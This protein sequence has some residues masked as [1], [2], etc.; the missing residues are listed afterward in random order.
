MSDTRPRRPGVVIALV[1]VLTALLAG[2]AGGA[3]TV[4][5]AP[6]APTSTAALTR[7][8]LDAWLD[9][10]VPAGLDR[11]GIAGAAVTVVRDG[12]VLTSRGYGL[13]DT[14]TG[15]PV[16]PER[17]LFR[18]GS[19]A[20]VFTATAVLQLVEQ[21]RIDLDADVRRHLDFPLPLRFE[22]PVTMRHLL[23]HSAGFEERIR[24]LI[25][26]GEGTED[27]RDH[28]A[29]DPPAQVFAP[30]TTP[31]YSNYGYGLAGYVV[32][33]VSGMP[34]ADYVQRFVLDPAGMSSSTFAQPLP[35]PLRA[36]LS[37]AFPTV[38][39]P[40]A[41]FETVRPSPAG[42]LTASAADMAR[43]MIAELGPPTLLAPATR[44]LMRSPALGAD[45]L[46]ALAE[47]PRTGLGLFDESRNGRRILGHGGD[48]Q[49]FHSHL[50][51]HPAE[52]TGI[53]VT[54][55][56]AG[57]GATDSLE[58][59]ETVL[60]GF[61]DRY[62]P[63]APAVGG[64]PGSAERAAQAQGTYESARAPFTT[65]LS[66]MNLGG[67]VT[68]TPRPDGTLL[69]APG[70]LSAHPAVYREVRPWVWQEAGGQRIV[71]MRL[72]QGRVA[73]LGVEGAF[74]LLPAPPER[75]AAIVLP[76]L[77]GAVTVLLGALVAWPVGAWLRRRY[78]R[79]VAVP[80][81]ERLALLATWLGAVAAVVA[82][83]GW[84]GAVLAISGLVDVPTPVLAGLVG[85]QVLG[86]WRCC[87]PRWRWSSACAAGSAPSAWP[88]GCWS[89]WRSWRSRASR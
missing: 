76:V 5:S 74:T 48:T 62:F 70:P 12:Q 43:F 53:F 1:L 65:F 6:A 46:G 69:F 88:G 54:M 35:A 25:T 56:G 42:S 63:G 61:A 32:E 11:A 59:R 31:A 55:N 45:T 37:G 30:G 67:Q 81:G 58:L 50:Q 39:A 36:R 83:G 89:S 60:H 41:P 49:F 51:L 9:G 13:A 3:S 38:D 27:L 21:G 28:L 85:L 18:V 66:A 14:A 23:T 22:P 17:T 79:R 80:R 75:R 57:R 71:A 77:A 44:D 47:G 52:R 7:E 24:G 33:R 86:S 34:F 68:V 73:A 8:D 15:A 64:V 82:I 29:T 20:K 16:D 10:V 78:G 2:C 72:E 19:V 40:A 87:R 4:T 26:L 84:V